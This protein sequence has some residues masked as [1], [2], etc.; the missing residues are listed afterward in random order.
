MSKF[1]NGK[2]TPKHP[3]KYIGKKVPTFRSSWELN[4][5][6][7]LDNNPAIL[8]WA[9]ESLVIPYRNPVSGKQSVYVPDFVVVY[10]DAN[11]KQHVEVWEVKPLKETG[12]NEAKSQRD[13]LVIAINIAKWQM[14]MQFCAAH[15][16][17]FRVVTEADIFRNTKK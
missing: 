17:F 14:A 2:Y 9:S 13:R 6:R 11:N 7:F 12:I 16:M 15:N 8:S 1:V 4:T 3:E 5:M 10:I